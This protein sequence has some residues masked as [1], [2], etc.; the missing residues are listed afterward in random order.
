MIKAL[1]GIWC[2]D[3][4]A[5]YDPDFLES[6]KVSNLINLAGQEV[7]NI[8]AGHGLVYLTYMW[9]DRDDFSIFDKEA[10]D[11]SF[12]ENVTKS[13][14]SKDK[15]LLLPQPFNEIVEFIDNSIK[16][17]IS[18]LIFSVEGGSR[19]TFAL[20]GYL[21][22]KYGWSYGKALQYL[23]AK[24][25]DVLKVP[26]MGYM[27]QLESLDQYLLIRRGFLKE[28]KEQLVYMKNKAVSMIY[29]MIAD[30]PPYG[31][32]RW[33]EFDTKY[34][35]TNAQTIKNEKQDAMGSARSSNNNTLVAS[36]KEM[37]THHVNSFFPVD[38]EDD[39][40]LVIV[41][42]HINTALP[43][44][45][46]PSFVSPSAKQ[47]VGRRLK[48]DDAHLAKELGVDNIDEDFKI[49]TGKDGVKSVLKHKI[50]GGIRFSQ[51]AS[52]SNNF[53][54]SKESSQ[55]IA[56]SS[57][58]LL[59]ADDKLVQESKLSDLADSKAYAPSYDIAESKSPHRFV[60]S[61]GNGGEDIIS[62]SKAI[63]QD[64]FS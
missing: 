12:H 48:F 11:K 62:L 52:T 31:Y 40:E 28:K 6:N 16:F 24:R 20:C 25:S 43:N 29:G 56:M 38:E 22:C 33:K 8:Y 39:N 17:G 51:D 4:E 44:G 19:C 2:G 63:E 34:L 26:N 37:S 9:E 53:R 45:K 57:G 32:S 14:L 35:T 21:M 18:V 55:I 27:R 41:L 1:D 13:S 42:S 60:A 46:D 64:D 7:Q 23:M 61:G 5:S 3:A 50:S 58:S 36:S 30:F 47:K 10:A 54:D 15:H 49:N 59:H